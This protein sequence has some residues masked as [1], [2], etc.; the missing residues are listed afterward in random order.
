MTPV[1][2]L[3]THPITFGP[4]KRYRHPVGD[5]GSGKISRG[6]CTKGKCPFDPIILG[7]RGNVAL[8]VKDVPGAT[9]HRQIGIAF[10]NKYILWKSA[11]WMAK[12]CCPLCLLSAEST[13]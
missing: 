10:R 11:D 4:F 3:P 5:V 1:L 12:Y 2:P 7:A 9:S 8:F 6:V 13:K